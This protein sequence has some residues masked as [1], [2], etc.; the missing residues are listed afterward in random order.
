MSSTLKLLSITTLLASSMFANANVDKIVTDFQT[1]RIK[2]NPQVKLDNLSIF[3]KK[4]LT[5]GW[6]GYV[7]NIK[8][9]VNGQDIEAKDVIFSDGK[10]ITPELLDINN[11]RSFKDA[12]TPNITSEYYN[13]KHLISGNKNAKN[14]VVIFSDPL[15]AFCIDYIPEVLKKAEKNKDIA[16]Y[17]YHFPLLRIHPAAD[18]VTRAMIVAKNKGVKEVEKKIYEANLLNE[19]STKESDEN[20]ILKAVNKV[21][22]TSITVTDI[23]DK[24]VLAE[25]DKDIAMSENMMVQGTPTLY[26]NGQ[27]D[28][29]RQLFEGL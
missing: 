10:M 29:T 22:K 4:E 15:C 13:D 21:L 20:V 8:A 18:V 26:V 2:A 27:M 17:Y 28:R 19:I 23:E 24:K 7:F 5:N 12:L 16:V 3:V 11:G 14:K 9:N 25:A 6:Y 1:K